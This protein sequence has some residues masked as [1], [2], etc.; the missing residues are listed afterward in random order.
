MKLTKLINSNLKIFIIVSSVAS[1]AVGLFGPFYLLYIQQIGGS[2]EAYGIA[3]ALMLAASAITSYF[4]GK[5]SDKIGRKPFLI[6]VWY[7][8]AVMCFSYTLISTIWQLYTIQVL[9]GI[10][11]AIETTMTTALIAD[12]T[13]KHKRG[14]EIGTFNMITGLCMAF[15]VFIGGI[16]VGIYGFHIVFYICALFNATAATIMFGI[17]ENTNKRQKSKRKQE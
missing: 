11:S 14:L 7:L 4:C 17:N 8:F 2:I 1:I 13:I 6:A 15:A 16:A 12:I 10:L 3:V 5:Y 9:E